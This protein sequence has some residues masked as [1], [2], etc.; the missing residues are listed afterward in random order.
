MKK[1]FSLQKSQ[2]TAVVPNTQKRQLL[3]RTQVTFSRKGVNVGLTRTHLAQR[4][5]AASTASAVEGRLNGEMA[6]F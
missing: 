1:L 2:I 6:P 5:I 4:Q 3:S